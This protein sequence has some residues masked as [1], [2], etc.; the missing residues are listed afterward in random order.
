MPAAAIAG[1]ISIAAVGGAAAAQVAAFLA[2][3]A[4]ASA[5]HKI[6]R[7]ARAR[8]AIE[9]L[10]GC[11]AAAAGVAVAAVAAAE[12][13]AGAAL[14][15]PA[16]RV[17]GAALAAGLWA[18]YF[19]ALARAFAAGRRDIDCGCSFG[20]GHRSLGRYQ[21]AR[22]G[23]LALLALAVAAAPRA[24]GAVA[25]RPS[26]ATLSTIG[27]ALAL[28]ALYLALDEVMGLR[29]LEPAVAR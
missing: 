10:T 5:A 15:L 12:A 23:G 29:E 13:S 19:A 16:L 18:G 20:D 8:G 4:L 28:L 27:G 25:G 1:P 6:A 2:A 26:G 11:G 22:T 14:L 24:A 9:S 21:L 3:L 17:L 7:P